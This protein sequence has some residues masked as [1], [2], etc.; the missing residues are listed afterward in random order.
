MFRRKM[1][2]LC[3]GLCCLFMSGCS[4]EGKL[5]GQKQFQATFLELFDTVTAVI[6]FADSQE[7]FQKSA[8]AIKSGLEFYHQL[9]DIY[10]EYE[11]INNLKTINDNAGIAPV[12]VDPAII[13]LL[14]DCKEYYELTGG[15]VNVA[16]GSVLKLWHEEREKGINDPENAAIPSAL[17]LEEAGRH[18]SMD[19]VI[20][21]KE[22]STVYIEDPLQSLDVGAVAKGWATQKVCESAAPGF[23]VSVGGNVCAT[24]PK[25]VKDG[26]WIV[27]IEYP[28]EGK[29]EYL[30]TI[31]VEK[32]SVVTSGNYQRYYTV[33]GKKYHHLID[34]DTLYPAEKY[35]S[36]TVVCEDSGMADALSTALY[37]LPME[38]GKHL[39]E[40]I[41]AEAV[42][43]VSEEELHYSDG[44]EAMIRS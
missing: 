17:D 16:M 39:L 35:V 10:N 8:D 40:K 33:D 4:L 22:A 20:I 3:L 1:Y 42:W 18:C 25:P 34:P 38:E 15:T 2:G 24:G 5:G 12:K 19:T 13:E 44:F 32:S 21:D 11:G 41:G 37:L 29:E 14:S 23:L 6:G 9:F 26:K 27:G 43:A 28:F 36:V 7:E 31:Y 30:H